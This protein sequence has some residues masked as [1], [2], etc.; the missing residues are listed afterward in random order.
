MRNLSLSAFISKR[1]IGSVV[2]LLALALGSR[3][4][5]VVPPKTTSAQQGA[6]GLNKPTYSSPIAMS[7]ENTLVWVVNPADDSVSVIRTDTNTVIKK[8]SVGDEPQ[9][10]ALDP[11]SR[12]AYVAN[13]AAGAVTV[14]KIINP[15]PDGFQAEVDSRIG[16]TGALTTGAEPWSIVGSPDGRRI[17]VANSGQD[18]IT[19]IDATTRQIIGDVDLRAS[20]CND[21]DR[22]RHFQPRGLAVTQDNTKLYVA[23]FLSFTRAGGK[24]GDDN[25][26]EGVVCRCDINTASSNI[27]D[28]RPAAAI[29]LAPQITG[30]QFPGLAADTSAFPNQ[31]QSVVVRGDRAYMPN[32]ASSPSGPLRFNVDTHAF[33]NMIDGVNSST[34]TDAGALNLHLGARNP[35]AGKKTLFFANPW[36]IAFTNQSGPGTAYVVSAASDLLVKVNVAGNG[37]LSF[38]VDN[39][40]TRYIDLNDPGNPATSGDK[41]GKNPR[42]IVINDAGTRAYVMNFV[43]RNVSVVDLTTDAVVDVIRTTALPAPG[44]LGERILV[45]AEMFFGSRGNFDRPSGTTVSTTER[46]SQA[47][48]Q[49]CSSCHF[50]GLTDGTIWLFAAGPR[51][52][53]PLNGGFNPRDRDDQRILNYSAIFDEVEDFDLNVRNVSGPGAL[54]A[55]VPCSEPP[56]ATSTFRATHGLI[57][58]D[59]GDINTPPCVINAF[60]KPNAGRQEVTVTLPGSTN[61]VPALTALRE[62]VRFAIRTPNSPLTANQVQGGVPSGE[63]VA[64]RNLFQQ[65]GCTTCHSGGKW[66]ISTKDFTS[67]PAGS[68]IF[69]ETSPAPLFGNPVGVQYL[70]RF[71]RNIGSFNLGVAGGSNPIGNNIGAAEKA[72]PA[73]VAGVLVFP[74][75][76]GIDYNGDGA[77]NGFNV[78]SLLGIYALPPYLHNGACETLACVVSDVNHRTANGTLPDR[79]ANPELQ[80]LVVRFLESIDTH[81]QPPN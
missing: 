34:Q 79:L 70:N 52:S 40:T 56:P 25:G 11:N 43:S 47:G 73:L 74:D 72:N 35:E 80:A 7:A 29:T 45:G 57:I 66:T 36:A 16:A 64:G 38:T 10:V 27:K 76:L 8:I 32:I 19:V 59:N 49:S 69:T 39:D 24:Q 75:A 51:K 62:W 81:T 61:P 30:F 33:L 58:G 46:L 37:A 60:A 77:G 17:F 21:P 31:L 48:W 41:A 20:L 65:A 68:E 23:R 53:V 44:S 4:G 50:Q 26:K 54:A 9:S 3:L 6:A 67:P 55:A 28:Y 13:A 18:T 5:V 71:L 1:P 63:I 42:G 14:I 78:P 2:L 15:T 22:N 12:F